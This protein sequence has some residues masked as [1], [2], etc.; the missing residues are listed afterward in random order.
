[1]SAIDQT[2]AFPVDKLRA[3]VKVFKSRSSLAKYA[4]AFQITTARVE[5][6]I[7]TKEKRVGIM[8]GG[9]AGT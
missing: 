4:T 2:A 9:K 6:A 5:R 3:D 8:I 7:K 1:M